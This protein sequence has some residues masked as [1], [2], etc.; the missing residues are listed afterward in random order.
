M[1]EK[2]RELFKYENE[3]KIDWNNWLT[4]F[5]LAQIIWRVEKGDVLGWTPSARVYMSTRGGIHTWPP[6]IALVL[7]ENYRYIIIIS[8]D[9]I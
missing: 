8:Y 7:I 5:S 2:C 4:T 1:T 3:R 9:E 6:K